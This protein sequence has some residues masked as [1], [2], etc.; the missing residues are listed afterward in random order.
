MD[1]SKK[2]TL[3]SVV[4]L[5]TTSLLLFSLNAYS[6]DNES[7]M[8]LSLEQLMNVKVET[9]TKTPEDKKLS[10]AVISIITAKDIDNYGYETVAEA[11]SHVAGFVDNYNLAQHNFGV[12]GINSGVRSGSRNI[13]VMIDGQPISFRSTTQ[14]FLGEELIPMDLIERIEIIKG[15]VSAL[16]G[17][18]AFLGVVNI[19]TRSADTYKESNHQLRLS[20]RSFSEAGNGYQLSLSGGK[21]NDETDYVYGISFTNEDRQGI[22][23]PRI[24]PNYNN[25]DSDINRNTTAVSDNNKPMTAYGRFGWD[26]EQNQRLQFSAHYQ[27]LDVENP[28][29]DINTLS[30][31]GPSRNAIE[32]YFLSTNY[33]V[34]LSENINAKLSV[35]YSSGNA[36]NDD[37][38]EI[39]AESFF[40]TR[41]IGYHGLDVSAELLLN[42][43][44]NDTLL[45]GFDSKTDNQHLETFTRVDRATR[46]TSTINPENNITITDIG[47]YA[48]YL[49][50]INKNWRANF[51]FRLDNDSIIGQQESARVGI[52]GTLP[53]DMVIKLLAGSSFQAP[54]P[55]LLFRKSVEAGDIIGNPDLAAQKANTLELSLSSPITDH[56][57]ITLTLFNTH[58][59]ELVSYQTDFTNLFATNG[60]N[61]ETS[62]IEIETRFLFNNFDAYFNYV[63]Q[64]SDRDPNPL[65]LLEFANQRNAELTSDQSANFGL[66][67]R[68]RPAKL[69]ISI[70]NSWVDNRSASN[71]NILIAQQAYTISKHL[72]STLTISTDYFSLI[73]GS[74]GQLRFQVR[75]LFD[76]N[77]VNPGFGGIEFPSLGRRF[78]LSYQQSF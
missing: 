36:N 56:F 59:D 73:K 46:N 60:A 22:K 9:V 6:T 25:I 32:N 42:L 33:D 3:H 1:N 21:N 45:I 37:K 11:L 63:N 70:D 39:G 40:M 34:N 67:Y 30:S 19:I 64:D 15:P 54:S 72:D 2:T 58:V 8:S 16:Y 7:L 66:N 38:V 27:K 18:N 17:A 61:A 13:K 47:L 26:V 23:L 43:R 51:G 71:Q 49:W 48:Q 75:D 65:T 20:S 5:I 52:V 68:W 74:L 53:H 12:R 31:F 78:S 44:E 77:F 4:I 76:S 28:F 41:R 50:Q 24:S 35:A 57:N 10:P 14:N 69:T 62:G 55:E 29:S